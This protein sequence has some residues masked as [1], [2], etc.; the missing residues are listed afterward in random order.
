MIL[1]AVP[2]LQSGTAT[3]NV[4]FGSEVDLMRR[5]TS[6]CLAPQSGLRFRFYLGLLTAISRHSAVVERASDLHR[7]PA[8]AEPGKLQSDGHRQVA[9]SFTARHNSA[10]RSPWRRPHQISQR[11][12][13]PAYRIGDGQGRGR[14]GCGPSGFATRSTQTMTLAFPFT[15]AKSAL[16]QKAFLSVTE[17]ATWIT[18]ETAE[19]TPQ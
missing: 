11:Y 5:V 3:E 7:L 14:R 12:H 10:L 15:R 8:V 19:T 6:V 13:W 16:P 2:P 9:G 17:A 4:R 1:P 18:V